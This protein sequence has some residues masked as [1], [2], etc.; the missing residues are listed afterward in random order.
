M[1]HDRIFRR[2]TTDLDGRMAVT[3]TA[4]LLLGPPDG[5]LVAV[6]ELEC[7]L[8]DSGADPALIR[9][10]ESITDEVA[11]A[12]VRGAR[13]PPELALTVLGL[14]V[15]MRLQTSY[16]QPFGCHGAHPRDWLDVDLPA[17]NWLI[18]GVRPVGTSLSAILAAAVRARGSHAERITV[19]FDV[20][21]RGPS[22]APLLGVHEAEVVSDALR[23]GFGFAVVGYGRGGTGALSK[24]AD[25]ISERGV[26]SRR[27]MLLSAGLPEQRDA[28][29]ESDHAGRFR[30]FQIG[31]RPSSPALATLDGGGW[32]SRAGV[33]TTD[34][35]VWPEWER[36]KL[37]SEDGS[38][39]FKFEGIG[40]A[41]ARAVH[42][43]RALAEE[44]FSPDMHDEGQ[45][46]VSYAWIEGQRLRYGAAGV[47]PER[48]ADY[49]ACRTR[50]FPA[51]DVDIEAL[52]EMATGGDPSARN[53]PLEVRTP[54]FAD[55][56]MMPHEW[57]VDGRRT[58]WK[59]D[60]TT[61]G[62]DPFFPGPVDVAWDVAGAI[63]EL[64]FDGSARGRFL[65]R[66]AFRSGD[67]VHKRLG[68][69]LRAYAR[70]RQAYCEHAARA[71]SGT[72]EAQ[73]LAR[74]A[75]RY[76]QWLGSRKPK[77]RA[78]RVAIHAGSGGRSPSP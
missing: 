63:V 26:S 71:T 21:S 11:Q 22:M 35:A 52:S 20:L 31:A 39:L 41:G 49:V 2:R 13:V 72:P 3:Q 17:G 69:W 76:G 29:I 36:A 60:G 8:V 30:F 59:V 33:S 16:A 50:L 74:D 5:A 38:R 61:H 78:N 48:I 47:A 37:V 25:A 46:F 73:G 55:A 44:G 14:R 40:A 62:D 70:F 23:R 42:R 10:C 45:G 12:F 64:G 77:S 28:T 1:N 68:P 19:P 54:V 58:L 75:A 67:D 43:A 6:G 34:V 32:R 4:E 18:V 56:R 7:A 9:R 24:V 27:I 65:R 57:I 66:Y 15:P 51:P 53:P